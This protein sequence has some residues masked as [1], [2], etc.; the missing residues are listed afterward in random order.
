MSIRNDL[1]GGT[2]WAAN[3]ILTSADLND[4]FDAAWEAAGSSPGFYLNSNFYDVYDNFDSY[5]TGAFSP[6][7]L[8]TTSGTVE[9]SATTNAGGS[10]Q[11]AK[12][13]AILSGFVNGSDTASL[14]ATDLTENRHV[15]ARLYCECT[16]SEDS[17]DNDSKAGYIRVR[18]GSSSQVKFF[19]RTNQGNNSDGGTVYCYTNVL[20]VALGSDNYDVYIGGKKVI[21]NYNTADLTLSFDTYV[22]KS[23]ATSGGSIAMNLY[24]D[25]V[26]QSTFDVE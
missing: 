7:S 26:R 19:E 4:T 18:I 25:D 20:V 22:S 15:W 5:S 14:A 23:T 3:D 9:I 1:L 13:Q 6:T 12:V 2:D 11:E 17:G 10:T 21:S 16:M 8:W 24:L